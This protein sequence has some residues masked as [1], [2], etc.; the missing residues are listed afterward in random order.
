LRHFTGHNGEGCGGGEIK[1]A[2]GIIEG[3]FRIVGMAGEIARG[4]DRGRSA[5][6]GADERGA[7]I[8]RFPFMSE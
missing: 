8:A 1:G 5:A 2:F 7:G 3:A 6:V 4:A